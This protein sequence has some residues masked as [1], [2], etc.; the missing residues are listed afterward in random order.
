MN[1][2]KEKLFEWYN[3]DTLDIQDKKVRISEK[4]LD[5]II[6]IPIDFESE[7]DLNIEYSKKVPLG[8]KVF[9]FLKLELYYFEMNCSH[10]KIEGALT[11]KR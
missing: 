6:K 1:V 4:K 8:G 10:Q 2:K 7:V 9:D 5:G 11:E 3:K